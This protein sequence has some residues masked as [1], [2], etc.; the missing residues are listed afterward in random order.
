MPGSPCWWNFH[1][2]GG[3]AEKSVLELDLIRDGLVNHYCETHIGRKEKKIWET[4]NLIIVYFR[5]L[6]LF[7][8]VWKVCTIHPTP[9]LPILFYK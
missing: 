6:W 7:V 4:Y 3:L 5:V 1:L 2:D 8:S 9:N